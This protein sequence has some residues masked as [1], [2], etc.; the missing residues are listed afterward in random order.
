MVLQPDGSIAMFF[1][2]KS[3][4]YHSPGDQKSPGGTFSPTDGY[5]YSTSCMNCELMTALSTN[6]GRS[7]HSVSRILKLPQTAGDNESLAP[8]GW[9]ARGGVTIA[10]PRLREFKPVEAPNVVG[11]RNGSRSYH[12]EILHLALSHGPLAILRSCDCNRW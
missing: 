6:D 11:T 5:G 9:W 2:R 10:A 7:F 8:S 1:M 12:L 4:N 3:G